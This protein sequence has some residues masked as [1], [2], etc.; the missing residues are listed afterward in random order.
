MNPMDELIKIADKLPKVVLEDVHKRI[1]DW[2][3]SGGKETDFIS[4]YFLVLYKACHTVDNSLNLA[5]DYHMK[6]YWYSFQI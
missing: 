1:G 5:K 4:F 3:A 6:L 2:L